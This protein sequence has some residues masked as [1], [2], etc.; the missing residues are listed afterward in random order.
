MTE[1][2]QDENQTRK[3]FVLRTQRVYYLLLS[4][5]LLAIASASAWYGVPY[6]L[7]K[8][9]GS[10]REAIEER[11]LSAYEKKYCFEIVLPPGYEKSDV[12]VQ[13]RRLAT[14]HRYHGLVIQEKEADEVFAVG[15]LGPPIGK[16]DSTVRTLVESTATILS[17]F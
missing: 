3:V 14:E 11:Y 5:V 10:W 17:L 8:G 7:K 15:K 2:G 12:S 9:P 13:I 1:W 6:I 4:I 16:N